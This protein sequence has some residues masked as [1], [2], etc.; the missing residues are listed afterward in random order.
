[1]DKAATTADA[2]ELLQFMPY[3]VILTIKAEVTRNSVKQR[4]IDCGNFAQPLSET[5]IS[6]FEK[7]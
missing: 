5:D 6:A 2:L 1:M 7:S 4:S 3:F